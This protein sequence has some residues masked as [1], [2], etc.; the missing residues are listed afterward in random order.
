M[1]D[2]SDS[3]TYGNNVSIQATTGDISTSGATLSAS[4]KF[5]ARTSGT[6]NNND[7]KISAGQLTINADKLSNRNGLVQ[8]LSSND[9]M[10]SFA[11][12]STTVPVRWPVTAIISA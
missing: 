3:Q 11:G 5:T 7:G 1:L 2:F 8:Q 6:L 9:L 10:F 12:G 4:Q